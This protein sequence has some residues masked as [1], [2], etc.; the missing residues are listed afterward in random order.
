MSFNNMGHFIQIKFSLSFYSCFD[1]KTENSMR[2]KRT[3]TLNFLTYR[4]VLI[5]NFTEY[6]SSI[7]QYKYLIVCNL[8]KIIIYF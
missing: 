5:C 2:R 3:D 6:R 1:F 8:H 7:L 4:Y